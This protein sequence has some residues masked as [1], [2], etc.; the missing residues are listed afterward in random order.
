MRSDDNGVAI[1]VFASYIG[2]CTGK[3]EALSLSPDDNVLVTTTTDYHLRIFDTKS[4]I[5]D[6]GKDPKYQVCSL[7]PSQQ[8][9]I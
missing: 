4:L 1:V 2:V 8:G 7:L 9:Q 6:K 5:S 3:V